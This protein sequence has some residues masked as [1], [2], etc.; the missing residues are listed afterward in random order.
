MIFSDSLADS[1]TDVLECQLSSSVL[2]IDDDCSTEELSSDCQQS[3]FSYQCNEYLYV[4]V[5]ILDVVSDFEYQHAW[6]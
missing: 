2:E 5:D 1:L 6:A 4:S 3:C